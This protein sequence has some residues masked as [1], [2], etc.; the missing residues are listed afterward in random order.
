MSRGGENPRRNGKSRKPSV[1]PPKCRDSGGECGGLGLLWSPNREIFLSTRRGALLCHHPPVGVAVNT[2]VY[3]R[4][5]SH[6]ETW[7]V[8]FVVSQYHASCTRTAASGTAAH[9][10][11]PFAE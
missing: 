10:H 9:R 3:I 11:A 2:G 8:V 7:G 1:D 4:N 5:N 6:L